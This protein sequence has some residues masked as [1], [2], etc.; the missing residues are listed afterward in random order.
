[1]GEVK[2]LQYWEG[3]RWMTNFLCLITAGVNSQRDTIDVRGKPLLS[4]HARPV[5]VEDNDQR[6][7][8]E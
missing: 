4:S 7:G 2:F 6:Q 3:K 8:S 1:M 5:C